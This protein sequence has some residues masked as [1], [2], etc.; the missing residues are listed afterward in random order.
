MKYF[1]NNTIT[2]DHAPDRHV[3][4]D[5]T[6][7]AR[8]QKSRLNLE[9]RR[10][11]ARAFHRQRPHRSRRAACHTL[12]SHRAARHAYVRTVAHL[13]LRAPRPFRPSASRAHQPNKRGQKKHRPIQHTGAHST[14]SRNHGSLCL[15]LTK[16]EGAAGSA[17]AR[18]AAGESEYDPERANVCE[19][20]DAA[21]VALMSIACVGVRLGLRW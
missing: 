15:P 19:S 17:F 12:R 10:A 16:G 1:R 14:L 9:R 20:G 18:S 5:R 2:P 13:H 11:G 3:R 21:R 8:E 7:P 6:S 4:Q